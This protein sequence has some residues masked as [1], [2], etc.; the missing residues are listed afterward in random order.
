MNVGNQQFKTINTPIDVASFSNAMIR[1]GVRQNYNSEIYGG[2]CLGF[3][4]THAWG[5]YSGN[6]NYNAED[7]KNYVG[8]SHF[9]T[10]INDNEQ[11][12]LG[13][14]YEQLTQNKPVII[15]VNGN[16]AGTSRHFVTVVGFKG[17]VKS[18]NDIKATDL[19]IIDSW[20][21]K[22][23]TM[24]TSTSRFLTTGAACHKD[25]SGYRI[26]YLK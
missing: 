17:T 22:L 1:R 11:V 5:L 7:G 21:G 14:V 26:Q 15:Q 18:A 12:L 24:D 6:T 4:Y 20:D 8:A 19:L 10:Y 23:E 16:K 2:A 3:S 9:S 13:V 25:Y